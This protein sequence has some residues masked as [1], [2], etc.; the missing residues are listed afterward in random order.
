MFKSSRRFN[1]GQFI[2]GSWNACAAQMSGKCG[3]RA[4]NNKCGRGRLIKRVK[5]WAPAVDGSVSRVMQYK[6]RCWRRHWERERRRGLCECA[7]AP[8]EAASQRAR[9]RLLCGGEH[10][11]KTSRQ[12]RRFKRFRSLGKGDILLTDVPARGERERCS[13]YIYTCVHERNLPLAGSGLVKASAIL[14]HLLWVV[15]LRFELCP[16]ALVL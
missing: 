10:Q 5:N 7:S 6:L 8:R 2:K 16:S 3:K 14:S 11:R 13:L 12:A 1:S 9:A 15:R 4:S